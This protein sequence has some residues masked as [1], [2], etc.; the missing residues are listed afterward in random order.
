MHKS[1]VLLLAGLLFLPHIGTIIIFSLLLTPEEII[2]FFQC[3]KS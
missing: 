2:V 1:K 3:A